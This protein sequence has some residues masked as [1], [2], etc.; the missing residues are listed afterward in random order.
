MHVHACMKYFAKVK[1]NLALGDYF[2]FV[3]FCL[4]TIHYMD[5]NCMW[6]IISVSD[7]F[8]ILRQFTFI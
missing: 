1:I 2:L 8:L 6:S 7:E 3:D 4:E 5:P